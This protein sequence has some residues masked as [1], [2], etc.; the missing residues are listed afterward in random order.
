LPMNRIL[1]LR[2]SAIAKKFGK[3]A[4]EALHTVF[5][6][7]PGHRQGYMASFSPP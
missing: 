5:H 7:V 6:L 4:I 2:S 1:P 3:H